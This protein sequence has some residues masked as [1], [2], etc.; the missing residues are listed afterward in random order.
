MRVRAIPIY[1]TRRDT[2]DGNNPPRMMPKGTKVFVL[3]I[4]NG[5]KINRLHPVEDPTQL[6]AVGGVHI[7]ALEYYDHIT[8]DI[9]FEE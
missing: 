7:K 2:K 9:V 5:C 3:G 1:K 4:S 6:N 8:A